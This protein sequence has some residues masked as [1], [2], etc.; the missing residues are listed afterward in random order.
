MFNRIVAVSEDLK[1]FLAERGVPDKKVKFIQNGLDLKLL[2]DQNDHPEPPLE[3]PSG[4][5]IFA[6]IGRLYPDKGH[7]F[8]LEALSKVAKNHPD[9]HALII[10]D[11][12]ASETIRGYIR[13][14]KLERLT[15]MCGVRSDMQAIY[16]GI[17]YLVIPSLTEGLPYVLL[18]AMAS[19]VPVLATAVGDIPKLIDDRKTGHLVPPGDSAGLAERMTELLSHADN[20]KK[21]E[22]C[23]YQRVIK[24]FSAE[25]MV[26]QTEDMYL[27]LIN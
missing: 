19:H 9:V 15:E 8:F 21:I 24:Q 10:G 25:Q 2:Y 3:I 17:D 16:A 27:E 22:E 14:F 7:R 13:E 6:V 12:P 23:A 5:K 4:R 1:Y 20:I 26:R 11:G 18:E